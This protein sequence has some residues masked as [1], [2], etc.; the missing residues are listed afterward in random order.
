MLAAELALTTSL[1]GP[2]LLG[3]RMPDLDLTA[4]GEKLRVFSLLN[5]AQPLLLDPAGTGAVDRRSMERSRS[6]GGCPLQEQMGAAGARGGA[7]LP[8]RS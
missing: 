1:P 6:T 3:R 7:R 8:P 4:G 2:P 5:G